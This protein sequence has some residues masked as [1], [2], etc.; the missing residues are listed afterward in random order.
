MR[1]FALALALALTPSLAAAQA[2]CHAATAQFRRVIDSD[3]ETGNLNRSV[4]NRIMPELAR[5]TQTCAAGREA[6]ASQA[7]S[8]LKRRY[9]YP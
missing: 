5:I 9:G 3:V 8:A 7:L 1:R 6:P 2:G 4:Y